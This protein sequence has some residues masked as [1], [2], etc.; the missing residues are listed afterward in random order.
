MKAKIDLE[1][2]ICS[3]IKWNNI[4][5]ALKDQ[6]L[7]CCNDEIIKIP[8]ENEDKRKFRKGDWIISKYMH[9]VMQILNNDKGTYETV[10][11]DG[12][13]RNDSYDFIE[14]NF[15]LW[16]IANAKPGDV[17]V[18]KHNQPFI[19][20]GIFDE[21]SVG[22]YCGIDCLGDDFLKDSFPCNWSYKEGVKPATQEQRDIL[23]MKM[24]DAGYEFDFE[25]KKLKKI[26]QKPNDRLDPLIDDEI[27]LWIKE[28]SDI[29]HDNNDIVELMRDMAYYVATLTRNLYRQ[30][31][32][33]TEE[34]EELCQDALDVF[35][36]L[37]NG[38]EP[39]EDYHKL[40][41]WLKRIKQREQQ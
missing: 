25:K 26:V 9:L 13:E 14:R 24:K 6:G 3:Y 20:N 27:D 19:Y 12:T 2:F 4:Q 21:E 23:F 1:K 41:D 34:D 33:W 22:A 38:L 17:L 11:T 8:Q 40:Y 28:N 36:A 15:K 29:H 18:S 7:K 10:E 39:L 5:D 16:T 37:G 35:E 32:K 31:S 30:K